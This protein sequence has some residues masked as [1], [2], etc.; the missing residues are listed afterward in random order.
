MEKVLVAVD[1][2]EASLGA[3]KKA[4]ELAS[5]YG[6]EVI[7]VQVEEE[8]PLLPAEKETE[9]AAR[10]KEQHFF[11]KPLELAAAYGQKYG[12][13]VRQIKAQGVISATILKIAN[14]LQVDLVVIGDS[15]RKGLGKMHFGSVSESISRS[16]AI[17]VLI[18]K[19]GSVDLSGL[20]SLMSGVGAGAATE[21]TPKTAAPPAALEPS[22]LGPSALGQR[23]RFSFGLL[24]VFA[25][26]YFI[27]ALL[28]SVQFKEL[29][30]LQTIGLP[31]G[32]WLGLAVFVGGLVITRIYLAKGWE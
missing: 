20:D 4:V 17:P 1:G 16:S 13:T 27:V 26:I 9:L 21:A 25:L 11:A 22:A 14:D 24:G 31:L 10:M 7:A 30:Q 15:G 3:V 28:T 8:I 32:I 5:R 2:Y 23:F 18:V 6:A 19:K 29:A 12:L